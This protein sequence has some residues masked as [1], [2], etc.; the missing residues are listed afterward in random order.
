MSHTN[1]KRLHG[2]SEDTQSRI[3]DAI[4]DLA[5]GLAT[6]VELPDKQ[7]YSYITSWGDRIDYDLD[8]ENLY[9]EDFT[10]S[11]TVR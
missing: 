3:D 1:R 5:E 8:R 6:G 10:V 11:L 9:V 2:F 4:L 7:G